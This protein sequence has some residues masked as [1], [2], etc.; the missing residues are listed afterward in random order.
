[1]PLVA[2]TSAITESSVARSEAKRLS[3]RALST[4]SCMGSTWVVGMSL[5][6]LSMAERTAVERPDSVPDVCRTKDIEGRGASR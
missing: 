6:T 4:R 1:M 2:R 5:L 3:A